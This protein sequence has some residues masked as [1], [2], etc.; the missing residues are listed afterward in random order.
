MSTARLSKTR[1]APP[2]VNPNII[3]LKGVNTKQSF[4]FFS[5]YTVDARTKMLNL[6]SELQ[7]EKTVISHLNNLVIM[8]FI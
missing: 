4:C 5:I 6:H 8:M 2:S 1:Y 7:R 3:L